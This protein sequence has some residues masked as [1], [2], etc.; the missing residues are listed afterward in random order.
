MELLRKSQHKANIQM[1]HIPEWA[2]H[3]SYEEIKKYKQRD[4]NLLKY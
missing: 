4:V 2:M 3:A 1:P